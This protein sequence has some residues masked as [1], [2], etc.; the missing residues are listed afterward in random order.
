MTNEER[1]IR[2]EQQYAS[3]RRAV[4]QLRVVL[5]LVVL[6]A[7]SAGAAV[8]HWR[9][10]AV[11]WLLS[12]AGTVRARSF[13]V[14][15]ENGNVCGA[16]KDEK[17]KAE[18]FLLKKG[19]II[20]RAG[21]DG[22]GLMIVDASGKT[23]VELSFN[24]AEQGASLKV[25]DASGKKRVD[26]GE[27]EPQGATLQLGDRQGRPRI[28]MAVLD[29]Q[30]ITACLSLFDEKGGLRSIL[31][32]DVKD[33]SPQLMLG[34]PNGAMHALVGEP[35][36][37]LSLGDSKGM[38]RV[39]LGAGTVKT[40]DGNRT[41]YQESTLR[42]FDAQGNAI[43]TSPNAMTSTAP[44]EDATLDLGSGVSMRLR[45]VPAGKFMMG[46][47]GRPGHSAKQREVTISKRF[48]M[49]IYEVTQRQYQ[50]LVGKNPSAD[51][52]DDN[53]VETVSWDEVI[54]FCKKLSE[55]TGKKV[56]LPTEAEWEYACRANSGPSARFCFGNDDDALSDY[57][58]YDGNSDKKTHPVG[59]KK[60]NR[61]GLYDMHGNVA[62]LCSG[63]FAD[64]YPPADN[65]DPQGSSSGTDRFTRG[66]FYALPPDGCRSSLRFKFTGPSPKG[67][68]FVGFRVVV[69][70][71]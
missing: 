8:V 29:D 1:L 71:H 63:Y 60:P 39:E 19:G 69:E 26:L 59:Q 27:C 42:L 15:D 58:W 20:I 67:S 50:Q 16:L 43:W 66:G 52:G 36:P 14:E 32:L 6:G 56:R 55:K 46:D 9:N 25:M 13:L 24:S 22:T 12:S 70:P 47:E 48:F 49:G 35:G 4:L 65:T 64:S 28:T 7:I 37:R 10:A 44:P 18:L 33:S 17:G 11:T 53:P 40:P 23:R 3:A 21:E 45:L 62:E 30:P 5:A 34:G 31:G 41:V 57:A 2:L 38:T 51:K 61:F 68:R 54:A